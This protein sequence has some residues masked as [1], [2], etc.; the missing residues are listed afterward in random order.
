MNRF[1]QDRINIFPQQFPGIVEKAIT[2][3]RPGRVKFKNSY[4]PARLHQPDSP[5]EIL[6]GQLVKVIGREGITLL[7]LPSSF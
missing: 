2:R 4:W 1:I 7:I 3:D 6:P 5:T